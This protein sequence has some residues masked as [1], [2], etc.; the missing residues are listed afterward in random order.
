MHLVKRGLGEG[1]VQG[2]I[3]WETLSDENGYGSM[4]GRMWHWSWLGVDRTKFCEST[5]CSGLALVD[6]V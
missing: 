5:R 1:G 6:R 3:E 4:N 2:S